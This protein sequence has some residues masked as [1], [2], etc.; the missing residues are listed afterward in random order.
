MAEELQL[1]I[2]SLVFAGK[3]GSLVKVAEFFNV[4]HDDQSKLVVAK[5]VVQRLEGEIAKLKEPEIVPYLTDVRNLIL[6][7]SSPGINDGGK[8]KLVPSHTKPATVSS[9]ESVHKLLNTSV[10]R[11]QFKINGQ[12]R[13]PEQK[14][15]ISFSS[16]ARHIQI[17]L[18]QG[19]VESENCWC[20]PCNH[21]WISA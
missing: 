10:V 12:I 6:E 15:K 18:T 7:K 3:R 1:E 11:R 2:Q 8:K 14:N 16:L 9:E 17:G 19:Y 5:L 13:E 20:H 21:T 4:E